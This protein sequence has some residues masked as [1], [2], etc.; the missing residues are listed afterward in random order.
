MPWVGNASA[1][2][3]IAVPRTAQGQ[4]QNPEQVQER[5]IALITDWTN[6]PVHFVCE[7]LGAQPDPW[8][9]DVMDAIME[10]H[11]V[12]LRACHGPGKT[13]LLSWETI[14]FTVTRPY[15]K[16]PTTAP[17]FNKQVKDVLWAE[18]HKWWRV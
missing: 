15:C 1:H 3:R 11:N 8:Q 18:I 10:E 12:A 13:T 5:L 6:N 4:Q 14:H 7:A 2:P 16:V 17:T 9:C